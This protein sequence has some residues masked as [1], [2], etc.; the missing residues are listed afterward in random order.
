KALIDLVAALHGK[1]HFPETTDDKHHQVYRYEVHGTVQKVVP[2]TARIMT[3]ECRQDRTAPAFN[4]CQP[5]INHDGI[6][7][8]THVVHTVKHDREGAQPDR[9][10]DAFQVYTVPYVRSSL[11]YICRLVEYGVGRCV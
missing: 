5:H 3:C 7:L 9:N 2:D 6:G 10:H 1:Q 8:I 4:G 11:C